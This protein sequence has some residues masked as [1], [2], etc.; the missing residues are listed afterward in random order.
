M[1]HATLKSKLTE[2]I[3]LQLTVE[4]HPYCYL[5][6]CG[7][8]SDLT[9]KDCRD[10]AAI[11]VSHTHIDHFIN[12]DG[13]M[14]HQLAIGRRVIVCGPAGL[15]RNVQAKML[16][17]NWNLLKYD[18]MAVSYEVRELH[19][20]GRIVRYHLVTPEW[21]LTPLPDMAGPRVYENEV[22]TVEAV[23]LDHG[24]DVVAYLFVEHPKV[25]LVPV[26]STH[27]PGKWVKEAKEALLAGEGTRLIQVEEGKQVAAAE[28]FGLFEV[29][30]G[31]RLAYVMD[32]AAT[33]A[34]FKHIRSLCQDAD[35]VYVEAYY[36][37]EDIEMATKNNHSMAGMSAK[38]LREAGVKQAFPIHFSRRYQDE[39]GQRDI[40][41]EFAANFR[42]EA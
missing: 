13:I 36:M 18:D 5:C 28:L 14:R 32:H 16:A 2:D 3:C 21:Q 17:F 38:V 39:E 24:V 26:R 1:I 27:K 41:A 12:F 8:A 4:N 31:F 6:D 19:P 23:L 7:M 10:T 25:R 33:E 35:E 9:V 15:A 29:E 37:M 11:F 40:L 20:D 22:F 34:N 30:P 42:A